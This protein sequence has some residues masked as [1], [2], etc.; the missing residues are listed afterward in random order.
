[1]MRVTTLQR[2][3]ET[4]LMVVALVLAGCG[5]PLFRETAQ[6]LVQG[7]VSASAGFPANGATVVFDVTRGSDA[8]PLGVETAT[9]DALGRYSVVLA[10]FAEPFDGNM[11][12]RASWELGGTR[13]EATITNITVPFRR[14]AD[15]IETTRVDIVLAPVSTQ[16]SRQ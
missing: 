10:V 3:G 15:G 1:M 12:V 2:C 16:A 6:A 13:Q 8:T 7:T 5:E 4:A 11:T 14:P 9:A